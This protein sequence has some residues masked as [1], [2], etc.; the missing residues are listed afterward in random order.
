MKYGRRNIKNGDQFDKYFSKPENDIIKYGNNPVIYNVENIIPQIVNKYKY[1]AEKISDYLFNKDI[2]VFCRNIWSFLFNYIQYEYDDFGKEQ[3]RTPSRSWQDRKTGIDCDC[4]SIFISCILSNK[5]TPHYI[6]IT[7]YEFNP[8]WQ[9]IYVIVPKS[10]NTFSPDNNSTYYTIDAVIHEFNKEKEFTNQKTYRME[11]NLGIVTE[12]LSG[13]ENQN[14]DIITS[15]L[16]GDLEGLGTAEGTAQLK[17]HL[18]QTR[19]W[20]AKNPTLYKAQGGSPKAGLKMYDY[21]IEHVDKPAHIRDKAFEVLARN[22][23]SYNKNVLKIQDEDLD[24]YIDDDDYEFSAL[25]DLGKAKARKAKR[26]EKKQARKEKK[27]EKKAIKKETKKEKKQERKDER[28]ERKEERKNAQGF[29][30]KI[31]VAVKQG[32][33][34]V[35]VK[36]NPAIIAARAGFLTAVR[37]NLFRLAS[38][39]APAYGTE[40][41]A[42][43]KG[44]NYLASKKMLDKVHE[45]FDKKLEGSKAELKKAVLIGA[46]KKGQD[47]QGLGEILMGL[48]DPATMASVLTAVSVIVAIINAIIKVEDEHGI[49]GL[50]GFGET[51]SIRDDVDDVIEFLNGLDDYVNEECLDGKKK[52]NAG[53]ITSFIKKIFGGNK[54]KK[55]ERKAKRQEKKATKNAAKQEKKTA[56]TEKKETKSLIKS[57]T[58]SAKAENTT[59]SSVGKKIV[60]G[61]KNF[62]QNFTK[63][64][65]GEPLE[66]YNELIIDNTD[67]YIISPK[68]S[69]SANDDKKKKTKKIIIGAVGAGVLGIGGI[70][71]FKYLKSKKPKALPSGQ[72]QSLNGLDGTK[73]RKSQKRRKVIKASL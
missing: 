50:Y 35:L 45:I 72:N 6:R 28:K 58:K 70:A 25:G 63:A 53:V 32:A 37:L 17:K 41:E 66:D 43:K 54:E 20:I 12:V 73:K 24:G 47:L 2:Y 16:A 68:N 13:I 51:D 69:Q 57:Q 4:F 60:T 11:S 31:G 64:Q 46:L 8:S 18:I 15:V 26:Q 39:L 23:A 7:K 36:Y 62:V 42:K 34:Q 14:Q 55:A 10:T 27:Q 61:A 22:E 38:R 30:R 49:E 67:D 9:H 1:Q 29:F 40:E 56:K 65:N 48:G 5:N 3:F 21:A 59:N 52:V 71:L 33:K 19:D 44:I